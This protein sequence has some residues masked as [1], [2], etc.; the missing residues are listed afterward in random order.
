[1]SKDKQPWLDNSH[2]QWE[3]NPDCDSSGAR[4]NTGANYPVEIDKLYG[5]LASHLVRI[6][7]EYT[8]DVSDWVV[9][10]QLLEG[11]AWIEMARWDCQLGFEDLGDY[12][13]SSEST[14]Q[15]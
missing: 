15:C 5:P 8:N 7:L 13:E 3:V 10:R 2:G 9:E 14:T 4:I 12:D 11:D 1:M 6:R